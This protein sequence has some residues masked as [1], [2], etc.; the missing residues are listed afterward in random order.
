MAVN[1]KRIKEALVACNYITAD[2]IKK[3]EEEAKRRRV[4]IVDYLIGANLITKDL[5]GQAIAESFGVQYADLNS[6]P[7]SR[8]QVLKLPEEFSKKYRAVIFERGKK[9]ITITT[10]DPSQPGLKEDAARL[11]AEKAIP[12]LQKEVPEI[13][14]AYSLP[15]DIDAVLLHYRKA[16][17]V[18]FAEIVRSGRQFAPEVIEQIFEDAIVYR[19]SDIHF[20]PH[21]E[22]V[23]IRFRIDGVMH[24]ASRIN[25]EYY[26]KILNLIKVRARLRID[27][28]FSAQDG[29]IRYVRQNREVDMRVSI[30]PTIEGESTVIRVLSEY[31]GGYALADLG[32]SARDQSVIEESANKPFGMIIISG[33]TGSGK[34]TTL[35]SVVKMLNKPEVNIMTIEDPVEYKLADVNQVQVNPQTNLTF[36]KGLK[37]IIRQDPNIILVGEIRDRE[38]AEIAVNAALTGHLLLSTFHAND[39]A[40]TIPRLL[41]MGVEP[42]LLASTLEVVVSQ[43]LVRKICESCRYSEAIKSSELGKRFPQAM[44]YFSDDPI[45]LYKGKGCSACNGAG[46]KGRTAIFEIIDI[47]PE[48]RELIVKKPTVSEIWKLARSQGAHSMYEDGIEKVKSGVTTIE[49]LHRVAAPPEYTNMLKR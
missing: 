34:T 28:H 14:I 27:E 3:A 4:S 19:A 18:R 6:N 39:A 43:R 24:E 7:P 21:G 10:D 38:T 37:S 46:Y 47:S 42:F 48:M 9:T 36:A 30:V 2:D 41:D 25:K 12:A 22:E 13:V 11:L 29:A 5:L 44:Q 20:E 31:I 45:T 15:E 23:V 40:T 16:L 26:D 49:E 8:D 33:P 35:Y 1:E 32:L 17:Q